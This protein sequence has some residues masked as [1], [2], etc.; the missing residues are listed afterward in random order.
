MEGSRCNNVRG[1][2]DSGT[3]IRWDRH[4][5]PRRGGRLPAPGQGA[6]F[7]EQ[8]G[9]ALRQSKRGNAR[10]TAAGPGGFRRH[11]PA[12]QREG[13]VVAAIQARHHRIARRQSPPIGGRDEQRTV[14]PSQ[15]RE[16]ASA[17]REDRP[18]LTCTMAATGT[19]PFRAV[20]GSSSSATRPTR[21]SRSFCPLLATG[22][23]LVSP[24]SQ[25]R[26]TGRSRV[27]SLSKLRQV[28]VRSCRSTEHLPSADGRR[29]DEQLNGTSASHDPLHMANLGAGAPSPADPECVRSPLCLRCA[30]NPGSHAESPTAPVPGSPVGPRAIW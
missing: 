9:E 16:G 14:A 5:A 24:G 18:S 8:V 7:D 21:R 15:A 25:R 23:S 27:V 3:C 30:R 29:R 2:R 22:Q 26:R 28:L 11:F 10:A 4:P 19:A 12:L 1:R 20:H 17:V 13:K 6:W